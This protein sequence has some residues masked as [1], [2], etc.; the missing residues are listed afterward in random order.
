MAKP[1]FS[2]EAIRA[3]SKVVTRCQVYDAVQKLTPAEQGEFRA[4]IKDP[5]LPLTAIQRVFLARGLKVN[6]TGLH[7]H[8]HGRCGRCYGVTR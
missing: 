8:R 4:A 5:T 1:V 6:V 7:H 3:A 2:V